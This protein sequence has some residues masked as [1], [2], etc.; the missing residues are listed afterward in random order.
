LP[1][2]G[3]AVGGGLIAGAG[4]VGLIAGALV[5][6]AIVT[7]V[8]RRR[9]TGAAMLTATA[10][11][12]TANKLLVAR[13]VDEV[14]NDGRMDVIDELYTPAMTL[15]TVFGESPRPS[16]D[17]ARRSTSS[18][19]TSSIRREPIAGETWI[20]CVDSQFS[21]RTSERPG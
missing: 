18:R 12:P 19:V 15:R 20:R 10:G 9:Q 16:I 3:A 2:L 13:L 11:R 14:I 5:L 17:R 7:L 21:C 6:A 4:P 8:V 1:L